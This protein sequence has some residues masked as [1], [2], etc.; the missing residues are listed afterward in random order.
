[1]NGNAANIVSHN[2]ALAGVQSSANVNSEWAYF[3]S[4]CAGAAN[5]AC[6]A[7]ECSKYSVAR[8]FDF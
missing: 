4:N 5:A 2:F 3:L 8:R 7:V 6:W 1:V